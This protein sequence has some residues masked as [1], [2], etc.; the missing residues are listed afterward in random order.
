MNLA[1]FKRRLM[2]DPGDRSPEMVRARSAG[3]EF[4]QAAAESGRFERA[5]SRAVD[6]PVPSGLSD[7][8]ILRQSIEGEKRS[9]RWVQWSA[10]AAALAIA[11]AVTVVLMNPATSEADLRRHVA[12]HWQ[13]DGPQVLAASLAD[14]REDPDHVQEILAEFGV[15]ASPELLEHVRLSKFCPTPDGKGAHLILE[16]PSGPVTVYYMP[17]TRLAESPMTMEIGGGIRAAAVN[18]ERGSVVLVADRLADGA[19]LA[20]EIGEQLAFAPETTI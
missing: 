16:T 13:L 1:E 6:V 7:R 12:W 5:L 14:V 15:Q 8:I 3:D 19:E 11:V 20:R 17:R 18:V 10:M 2:T 4:E 9:M